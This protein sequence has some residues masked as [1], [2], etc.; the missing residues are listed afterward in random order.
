MTPEKMAISN[1]LRRLNSATPTL[2]LSPP[3]RSLSCPALATIN[4]PARV[5]AMPPSVT[6]PLVVAASVPSVPRKIGGPIVPMT[7]VRPSATAMP[8]DRPR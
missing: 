5:I 7:V 2:D 8:S 4:I 6:C 1:P 3:S